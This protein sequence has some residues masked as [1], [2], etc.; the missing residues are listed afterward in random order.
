MYR[1]MLPVVHSTVSHE[2]L[3]QVSVKYHLVD[4]DGDILLST[5]V[6]INR[7]LPGKVGFYLYYFEVGLHVPTLAFFGLVIEM[8]KIHT[9]QLK[10]NSISKIV[11]FEFLSHASLV[12]PILCC[13]STFFAFVVMRLGTIF[14]QG[15]VVLLRV[16]WIL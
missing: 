2:L 16:F 10:P 13:S 4:E 3:D 9:C 12:F 6:I 1:S 11:Y 5:N 7:P 15:D 8:Y 14:D